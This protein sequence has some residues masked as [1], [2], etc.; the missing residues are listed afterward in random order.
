MAAQPGDGMQR[1]GG[2]NQRVT[3]VGVGERSSVADMVASTD[4]SSRPH[5]GLRKTRTAFPR[6]QSSGLAAAVALHSGTDG[7]VA[8]SSS[9]FTQLTVVCMQIEQD[10]PTRGARYFSLAKVAEGQV[11]VVPEGLCVE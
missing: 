11:S 2:T 10:I 8:A 4:V 3:I 7:R 9:A 5:G 1:R 6:G